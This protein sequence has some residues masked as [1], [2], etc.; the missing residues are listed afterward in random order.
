MKLSQKILGA[1]NPAAYRRFVRNL[2]DWG[3]AKDAFA[4]HGARRDGTWRTSSCDAPNVFLLHYM[5]SYNI[6]KYTM[7]RC[8]ISPIVNVV[9]TR[10][11]IGYSSSMQ[12]NLRP[13][14]TKSWPTHA[15]FR[16]IGRACTCTSA[17][18]R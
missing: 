7:C 5:I 11:V 3:Q 10:K 1:P 9:A 18:D 14:F 13:I 15:K 4:R 8:Q 16:Q 2:G 6:L 17:T 12:T